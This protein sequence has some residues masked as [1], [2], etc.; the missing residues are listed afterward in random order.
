[1]GKK[2]NLVFGFLPKFRQKNTKIVSDFFVTRNSDVPKIG[3]NDFGQFI[4]DNRLKTDMSY[5]WRIPM[6]KLTFG[7]NFGVFSPYK[8][9]KTG[10]VLFLEHRKL[11]LCQI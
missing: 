5:F 3:N 4:A 10:D 1:M 11:V 6:P 7:C 2:E 8:L 9:L